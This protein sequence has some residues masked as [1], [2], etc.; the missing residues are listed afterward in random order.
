MV[1]VAGFEIK[2]LNNAIINSLWHNKVY[3]NLYLKD[4]DINF[5]VLDL[6]KI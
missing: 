6:Y 1:D 3:T 2:G 4:I 5:T